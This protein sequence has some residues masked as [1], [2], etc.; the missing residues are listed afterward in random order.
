MVALETPTPFLGMGAGEEE[1]SVKGA[2]RLG[3]SQSKEEGTEEGGREQRSEEGRKGG[4][5]RDESGRW[6][7][8]TEISTF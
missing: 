1:N 2:A 6:Q 7:L 4:R 3:N 5:E 8:L